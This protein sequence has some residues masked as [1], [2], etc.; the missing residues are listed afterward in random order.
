M[1]RQSAAKEFAALVAKAQAGDPVSQFKVAGYHARGEGV[2]QD[3]TEAA[4]WLLLSAQQGYAPAQNNLAVCYATGAG[5]EKDMTQAIASIR[6]VGRTGLC[7]GA[8][9]P[10]PFFGQGRGRAP[11]SGQGHRMVPPSPPRRVFPTR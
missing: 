7:P 10:R 3:L 1:L 6:K 8:M 9:L 5:V 2:V 4:K 11:R